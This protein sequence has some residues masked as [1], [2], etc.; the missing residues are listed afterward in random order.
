[1]EELKTLNFEQ[2]IDFI[3]KTILEKKERVNPVLISIHGYPNA[4][5][6]ELMFRAVSLLY[7]KHGVEG[8]GCICN[9]N[10]EEVLRGNDP[11]FLIIEDLPQPER[12]GVK[13]YTKKYFGRD[14]DLSVYITKK[15]VKDL[16]IGLINQIQKSAY[17]LTIE[18]PKSR[19]KHKDKKVNHNTA[20]IMSAYLENMLVGE[21][22]V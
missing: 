22:Q 6:T 12:F 10:L 9:D 4:G 19:D 8:R 5:K 7:K 13:R 18:N 21:D 16:P 2:G 3:A 20:E 1:M 11:A 15:L 14:P 17:H